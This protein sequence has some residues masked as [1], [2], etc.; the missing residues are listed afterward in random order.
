MWQLA[1]TP[2][3]TSPESA[4]GRPRFPGGRESE[5]G[6][7]VDGIREAGVVPGWTVGVWRVAVLTGAGI[8]T[9]SGISDFRRPQGVWSGNPGAQP[10]S[11]SPAYVMDAASRATWWCG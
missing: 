10:L 4:L 2:A 5:R 11:S 1:P 8:S 3:A 7:G 6:F 9:E